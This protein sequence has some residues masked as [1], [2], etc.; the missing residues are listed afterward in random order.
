MN[1]KDAQILSFS[2]SDFLRFSDAQM[3]A[4]FSDSQILRW[5]VSHIFQILRFSHTPFLKLSDSH[6]FQILSFS[7]L[8]VIGQLKSEAGTLR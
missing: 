1:L 7:A 5:C 8:Q 3:D 2:D 4:S 6:F